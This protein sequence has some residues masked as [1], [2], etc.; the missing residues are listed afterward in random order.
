MGLWSWKSYYSGTDTCRLN[1]TS[2]KKSIDYRKYREL[3]G[4]EIRN[5]SMW[6]NCL[7]QFKYQIS[8]AKFV[9]PNSITICWDSTPIL[10]LSTRS[11]FNFYGICLWSNCALWWTKPHILSIVLWAYNTYTQRQ[12]Y[13]CPVYQINSPKQP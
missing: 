10:D 4:S 2:L 11:L 9:N 13:M 6:K 12:T 7:Q 1:S 5:S 8:V 3:A